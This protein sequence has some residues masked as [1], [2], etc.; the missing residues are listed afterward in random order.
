[1]PDYDEFDRFKI[2]LQFCRPRAVFVEGV[3]FERA[4]FEL[5]VLSELSGE[6]L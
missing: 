6:E 1:M 4:P 3:M 2:F 5:C